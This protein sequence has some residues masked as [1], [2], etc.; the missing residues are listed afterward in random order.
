MSRVRILTE[1]TNSV[2]NQF[3]AEIRDH[4][5]QKD[6]LRFRRNLE[7]TGELFAYEISKTLPFVKTEITTPL[8]VSEDQ[9]IKEQPVLITI[10][11]AGLPLHQ[12]LLNYLDKA[13]NGYISAYRKHH[14]DGSFD[15]ELEYL[16]CPTLEGRIV[17]LSD[18]MLATGSSMIL[19]Y[20]ALLSKGKPKHCHIV[21]L[22]GSHEGLEYA[23]KNLPTN[24]TIWLGAVDQEMTAQSYIVPGLGD[25]GDLAFGTK[26]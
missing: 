18:P 24:T 13:D 22:I 6:R 26:E 14:K 23:K 8:G 16:A 20:K 12:G 9:L 19:A 2:F 4:K 1:E 7:R 15:I 11:R 10:L 3:I 25:A 17:I 21:S 5:I